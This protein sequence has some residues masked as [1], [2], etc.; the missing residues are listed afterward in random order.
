MGGVTLFSA[1][2]KY[3]PASSARA[4]RMDSEPGRLSLTRQPSPRTTLHSSDPNGIM[5]VNMVD[6]KLRAKYRVAKREAK[7]TVVNGIL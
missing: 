5:D 3:R 1:W 7:Y 6:C 2:H 4:S